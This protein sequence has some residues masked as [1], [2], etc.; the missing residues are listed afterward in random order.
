MNDTSE[1]SFGCDIIKQVL[2]KRSKN[3]IGKFEKEIL[4][5]FI[6]DESR[7]NP[8][9]SND[10]EMH[11]CCFCENGDLL[12]QWRGYGSNGAGYS[13]GFDPHYFNLT[14]DKGITFF[15]VIYKFED[16]KK[17]INGV[18]DIFFS[19][20]N[21][22]E[23][24]KHKFEDDKFKEEVIYRLTIEFLNLICI[25]KS[26][27]FE[28]EKEWRILKVINYYNEVNLL[29]FR[30]TKGNLIPYI[31]IAFARDQSLN[32]NNELTIPKIH[33]GPTLHPLLTEKALNLLIIKSNFLLTEIERSSI[34]YN[35]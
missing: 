6:E 34:P 29:S 28:E 1:T 24:D 16:Q 30:I 26:P 21:E 17:V 22:L 5:Y 33:Y 32:D 9:L 15:K 25:F 31:K 20:L 27:S 13:V 11:I 14:T 7:I 2:Y 10:I 3:T 12:S 23:V 35:N 4:D 8:F 19:S 18:L